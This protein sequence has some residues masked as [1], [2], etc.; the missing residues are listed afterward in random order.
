MEEMNIRLFGPGMTALHRAGLAGLY[1]TLQAFEQNGTTVDGLSWELAP[2]EVT[3]RWAEDEPEPV[4]QKLLDRS[5]RVDAQ[6]FF[7]LAGLEANVAPTA[8]DKH[9]LHRALTL[10]FLQFGPHRPLGDEREL[11]YEVDDRIRWV[12][13]FRP[14]KEY[15]H[16]SAAGEFFTAAG[17]WKGKVRLAG[18]LYPGGGQRHVAFTRTKLDEPSQRAICLVFAPVGCLYFLLNRGGFDQRYAA[19]LVIP[20]VTDLAEYCELRRLGLRTH[21]DEKW[22]AGSSDAALRFALLLEEARQTRNIATA[23]DPDRPCRV[24]TFGTVQWNQNQKSRT[25]I[26]VP[27]PDLLKRHDGRHNYRLAARCFPNQVVWKKD[28]KRGNET[29]WVKPSTARGIVADNVAAGRPW[30]SGFAD[31]MALREYRN[32]LLFEREG[33]HQMI[34]EAKFDDEAERLFVQACHEAWRRRMGAL[35]ERAR[36][37]NI[38]F[39]RLVNRERERVRVSFSRCKNAATLRETITD[40]WARAG[41]IPELAHN[42]RDILPLLNKQ[43]WRKARDLAMLALASYQPASPEEEEALEGETEDT[44][45]QEGAEV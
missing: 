4:F 13:R 15:R 36:R 31:R 42:W 20:N 7:Q 33:L 26:L 43:N 2:R 32:S 14:V 24:V 34:E 10:T 12:P 30:Y 1:M 35:A 41:S 23:V 28:E 25:R 9:L 11:Q 16:Q 45:Q 18:W 21:V 17:N 44:T 27:Q 38:A 19:A 29:F 22:A 37:E 6:G 39:G 3:L 40:F 8:A 5:F